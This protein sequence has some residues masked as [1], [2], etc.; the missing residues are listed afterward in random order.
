MKSERFTV[1]EELQNSS[2]MHYN[3]LL[4][5]ACSVVMVLKLTNQNS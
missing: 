1:C 4:A 2:V 5:I 3:A